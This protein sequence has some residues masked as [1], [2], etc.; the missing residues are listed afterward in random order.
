MLAMYDLFTN[1][2]GL[3]NADVHYMTV[4]LSLMGYLS[5][6]LWSGARHQAYATASLPVAEGAMSSREQLIFYAVRHGGVAVKK[7]ISSVLEGGEMYSAYFEF[8]KEFVDAVKYSYDPL[9]YNEACGVES[10]S[11]PVWLNGYYIG[12][13]EIG[14]DGVGSCTLPL[15]TPI[16]RGE[17]PEP[18]PSTRGRELGWDHSFSLRC[19]ES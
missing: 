3:A 7:N 12:D 10:V 4:R 6:G 5:L 13:V 2:H 18:L 15:T 9:V 1:T 17:H 11:I 19:T 8:E 14:E 16:F